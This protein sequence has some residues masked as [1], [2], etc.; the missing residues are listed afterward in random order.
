LENRKLCIADLG[1]V[2]RA[3]IAPPIQ[4]EVSPQFGAL[5]SPASHP[6]EAD[7]MGSLATTIE[8]AIA[9]NEKTVLTILTC[10]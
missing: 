6:A 2:Y 4:A 3:W 10:I 7:F 9:I 8:Q 1:F 5:S